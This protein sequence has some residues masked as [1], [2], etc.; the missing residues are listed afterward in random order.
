MT[1]PFIAIGLFSIFI[2]VAY[3]LI[4][5]YGRPFIVNYRIKNNAIEMVLFDIIP[6]RVVFIKDI[7]E[8]KKVSLPGQWAHGIKLFDDGVIIWK[9]GFLHRKIFILPI[10]SD[11]FVRQVQEEINSPGAIHREAYRGEIPK[12]E[13]NHWLAPLMLFRGLLVVVTLVTV[14]W[15]GYSLYDTATVAKPGVKLPPF[16]YAVGKRPLGIAID[17][18]GNI[19]VTNYNSN[20]VTKLS[21]I[22]I[23]LGTYKTGKNPVGIAIDASGN[24]WVANNGSNSVTKLGP[25]GFIMGTYPAGKEPYGIAMDA[26]ENLW[27]TNRKNLSITKLTSSGFKI[28]TYSIDNGWRSVL[29]GIVLDKDGNAWVTEQLNSLVIEVSPTGTHIG[30]YPVSRWPY[31]LAIDPS[32]NV[33]IACDTSVTEL[34]SDGSNLGTYAA[35]RLITGPMSVAVDASGYVWVSNISKNNVIKFNLDGSIAKIYSIGGYHEGIAIDKSGNVWVTNVN[36]DSV[37]VLIGV[38]KG[39]QYFPY[40][41]PQFPGGGNF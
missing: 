37:S 1:N 12:E 13:K 11:E 36:G 10:N 27:V 14:Y 28:G 16:T 4:V 7:I 17:E 21:P 41:G 20:T 6:L 8:I 26:S 18:S 35:R 3:A 15:Y 39:P 9:K 22:G 23:A 2:M 33:W 38:A 24:V 31:G 5:Q 19:W 34:S 25:L 32:G 30:T 40:T 29:N